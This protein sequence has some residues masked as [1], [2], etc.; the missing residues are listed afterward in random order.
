MGSP[1]HSTATSRPASRCV[2][3]RRGPLVVELAERGLVAAGMVA[4]LGRDRVD[5]RELDLV[6]PEV[7]GRDAAGDA[8]AVARHRVRD[9]DRR[10]DQAA[11][12]ERDQLGVARAD[13]DAVE[14]RLL[15]HRVTRCRTRAHSPRRRRSRCP[16]GGRGRRGYSR[17]GGCAASSALDSAAPMKPTGTPITAA[18]RGAPCSIS[19]SRRKSAVGAL[20]TATTEPSS[21][22]SPELQRRRRA[23]RAELGGQLR[24]ACGS[25]SVQTTSLPAGRRERVTPEATIEVSHRI[26]LPA[27]SAGARCRAEPR[28]GGRRRRRDRPC[29][30]RGSCARRRSRAPDPCPRG[31]PRC[32]SSRTSAGRSRRRP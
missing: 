29:R 15:R 12:L 17:R 28:R 8:A 6:A 18:G 20:P 21:C 27:C 24:D 19:S 2:G 23:R 10:L 13:A 31:R 7:R 5:H 4:L 26:G 25:E 14:R 3:E 32:G 16:R 9:H 1:S 11:R 30:R 22:V